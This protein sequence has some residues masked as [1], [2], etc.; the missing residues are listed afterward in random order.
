MTFLPSMHVVFPTE[1]VFTNYRHSWHN[2]FSQPM[3]WRTN[4]LLVVRD[5][6]L[7]RTNTDDRRLFHATKFEAETDPSVIRLNLTDEYERQTPFRATRFQLMC[8]KA[9]VP[10]LTLKF[11]VVIFLRVFYDFA[12]IQGKQVSLPRKVIVLWGVGFM[13]GEFT[14]VCV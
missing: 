7:W 12:G 2:W 1:H 11:G 9:R 4:D 5:G 10:G 6:R 8:G 13:G 3:T 14:S